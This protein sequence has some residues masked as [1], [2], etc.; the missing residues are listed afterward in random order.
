MLVEKDYAMAQEKGF[1]RIEGENVLLSILKRPEDLEKNAVIVRVFNSSD[2]P[3]QAALRFRHPIA[4]AWTTDLLEQKSGT[5]AC[6]ENHLTLPLEPRK[7]Q[8]LRILLNVPEL[9]A[10]SK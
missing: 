1:L 4:G 6:E 7:I 3:A 5:L 2:A 10:E 9:P 8:T